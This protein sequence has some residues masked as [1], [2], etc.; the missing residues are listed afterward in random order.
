MARE[1]GNPLSCMPIWTGASARCDTSSAERGGEKNFA[2][3][4]AVLD[5]MFGTYYLPKRELPDRYGIA[6]KGSR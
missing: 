2:S 4:F 6:D 3:T 5:L 1:C